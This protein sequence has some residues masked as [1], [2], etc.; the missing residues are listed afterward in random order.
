VVSIQNISSALHYDHS[1][2]LQVD[3]LGDLRGG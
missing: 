1:H 3:E 2:T